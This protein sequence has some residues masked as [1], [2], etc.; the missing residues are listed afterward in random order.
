MPLGICWV[1]VLLLAAAPSLGVF[2]LTTCPGWW[3]L[4]S[5]TVQANFSLSLFAGTYYELALHDYTQFPI[6]P[7]PTC[8][9][10][11]KTVDLSRRVVNDA[12][13]VECFGAR[14]PEPLRFNLTQHSGVFDGSW[15]NV[16]PGVRIPDAVVDFLPASPSHPSQYSFVLEFQCVQGKSR[17]DFTGI[18]WYSAIANPGDAFIDA[19]LGVYRV[20][21]TN[22]S[23]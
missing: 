18:N 20:P 8:V 19:I 23:Y 4:Q 15:P 6:C 16:L 1:V 11:V 13:E 12:W 10:S 9:R 3:E 22:C 17:I 7:H 14:Y 5:A 21:Q 2:N